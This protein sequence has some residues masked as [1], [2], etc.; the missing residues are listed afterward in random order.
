MKILGDLFRK[1]VPDTPSEPIA[2]PSAETESPPIPKKRKRKS[3]SDKKKPRAKPRKPCISPV[4]GQ[5][6]TAHQFQPGCPPGP[7]R[8]PWKHITEAIKDG[9]ENGEQDTDDAI[10]ELYHD[11]F[12]RSKID[13]SVRNAARKL[14][15]AYAFGAPRQSVDLNTKGVVEIHKAQ[16]PSNGRGPADGGQTIA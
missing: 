3:S 9:I 10:R 11:A 1:P 8:K 13:P 6:L 5:D 15:L 4:N 7:G 14:Y 2:Q 12:I 16:L